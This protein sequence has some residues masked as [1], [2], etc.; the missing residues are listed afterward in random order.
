MEIRE[1]KTTEIMVPLYEPHTLSPGTYGGGTHVIIEVQTD[2]GLIGY[3]ESS[4]PYNHAGAIKMLIDREMIP[5]LIGENPLRVE[6]LL[7]KME[8]ITRTWYKREGVF[9]TSG[10]EMA[11]F[12]LVGKHFKVPLH[13][14]F[15]GLLRETVPFVGY[16]FID[17]PDKNAETAAK[18][19]GDGYRTIKLKIGKEQNHNVESVKK[20]RKS[21]GQDIKLRLDANQAWNTKEAIRYIR[22]LEPFDLEWVEQPIPAW[23]LEGMAEVRTRVNVPIA[24]DESCFTIEDAF[25]IAKQRA[26]DVFILRIE[27]AGGLLNSKRL[28]G[29]AMAANISMAMGSWLE[30]GLATAAKLHFIAGSPNFP[31]DNDTVLYSAQDDILSEKLEFVKGEIAVPSGPGLGVEVDPEK[32][33]KF[34]VTG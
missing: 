32:L 21:I 11:L 7:Q 16:L 9:A 33:E 15:G 13:A 25:R 4:C 31:F 6:Y 10:V 27:E 17:D 29:I 34:R 2:G 8:S 12:D 3:G 24:A 5:L 1:I 19:V 20:V 28:E 26:A 14:L 23:D 22:E 30:T 18:Y